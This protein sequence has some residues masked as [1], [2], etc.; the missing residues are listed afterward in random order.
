MPAKRNLLT[1]EKAKA[2]AEFVA[3]SAADSPV[4]AAAV[5]FGVSPQAVYRAAAR[6]GA[7]WRRGLS[8]V[9]Y[10]VIARLL[11]SDAALGVVGAECG[12]TAQRVQKVYADCRA[13][14]IPVRVRHPRNRKRLPE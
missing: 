3:A 6:E 1:P 2:I 12:V 10:R 13:A 4:A 7:K 5:E 9:T 14:G 8:V 11:A